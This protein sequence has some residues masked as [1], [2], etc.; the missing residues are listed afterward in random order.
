MNVQ[1]AEENFEKALNLALEY[2]KTWNTGNTINERD[3][4]MKKYIIRLSNFAKLAGK[5]YFMSE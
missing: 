4:T 3:S 5:E 1:Y 2:Y